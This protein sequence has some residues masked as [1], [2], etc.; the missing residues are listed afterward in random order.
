MNRCR[1]FGAIQDAKLNA[2][3]VGGDGHRAAQRV[4][5]FDQMPLPMPRWTGCSSSGRA[6]RCCASAAA[7]SRRAC[8]RQRNLAASVAAA[9]DDH[10]KTVGVDHV[11]SVG[12]PMFHVKHEAGK[13]GRILPTRSADVAANTK[14]RQDPRLGQNRQTRSRSWRKTYTTQRL[15]QPDHQIDREQ[16]RHRLGSPD[17]IALMAQFV[18][19]KPIPQ[20][21]TAPLRSPRRTSSVTSTNRPSRQ[22]KNLAPATSPDLHRRQAIA[23]TDRA[24]R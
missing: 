22:S 11:N 6:F 9:D 3:L 13:G 23:I 14:S 4:H 7:S 2:R 17:Q 8:G 24:P 16:S 20:S 21:R 5:L 15:C 1:P 19:V 18:H 10:I 12:Q